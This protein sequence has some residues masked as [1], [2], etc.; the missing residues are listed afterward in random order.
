LTKKLFQNEDF[1]LLENS[2]PQKY[3]LGIKEVN[4][5]RLKKRYGK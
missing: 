3:G 4:K 5:K 1:K 2:T